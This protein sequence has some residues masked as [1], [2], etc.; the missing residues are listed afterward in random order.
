MR[1]HKI[2]IK[3]ARIFNTYGPRMQK[4][5]G[6]VVSNFIAQALENKPL[7]IYGDG[8]QTR[9]FCFLDD[10]VDGLILLMNS[11]PK[12]TGPINLGNPHELTIQSLAEL[13]IESTQSKSQFEYRALPEDDP[14]VR[15]PDITLAKKALN[16]SPKIN[17]EKG[18]AQ[19][20]EF[21][22]E[23]HLY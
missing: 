8:R 10:L 17:I 14:E 12:C 20:I 16:W 2:E 13:I 15:C 1:T 4:D 5:D 23:K 3:I 22:F 7:T 6:R 21:F 19:T 9:S 11:E 18:L